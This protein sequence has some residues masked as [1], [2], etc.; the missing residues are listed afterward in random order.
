MLIFDEKWKSEWRLRG[1][2][3][4]DN[5]LTSVSSRNIRIAADKTAV[6]W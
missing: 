2:L 3:K 6:K 5:W 4:R 1:F